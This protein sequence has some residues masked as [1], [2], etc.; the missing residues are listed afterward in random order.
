MASYLGQML[1]N[2]REIYIKSMS[3]L[4]RDFIYLSHRPTSLV[5]FVFLSVETKAGHCGLG[6]G[7]GIPCVFL[8]DPQFSESSREYTEGRAFMSSQGE[9]TPREAQ[10]MGGAVCL[11][12]D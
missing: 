9:A 6:L 8:G 1:L 12:I 10:D 4:L 7:V 5:K 2:E 11:F 3:S